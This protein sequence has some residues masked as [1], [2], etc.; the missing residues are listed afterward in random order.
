MGHRQKIAKFF[1]E[2]SYLPLYLSLWLRLSCL[3]LL[4]PA[5]V[6]PLLVHHITKG[7]TKV[8]HEQGICLLCQ[9]IEEAL[10]RF[11][12][13]AEDKNKYQLVKLSLDSGRG[14]F[15]RL[16]SYSGR[17]KFSLS[18]SLRTSGELS[19]LSGSLLTY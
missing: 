9:V 18:S 19:S 13:D 17:D 11:R 8:Y 2:D 14:E 4:Y 3:A 5:F 15:F 16:S 1:N 12:L 10:S 6:P 7:Q